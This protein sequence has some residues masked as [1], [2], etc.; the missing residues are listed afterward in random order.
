[1]IEEAEEVESVTCGTI[2]NGE[3]YQNDEFIKEKNLSPEVKRLIEIIISEAGIEG[4]IPGQLFNIEQHTDGVVTEFS[5]NYL[6]EDETYIR[7]FII[8][9]VK[10]NKQQNVHYM[11][12]EV[13][14]ENPKK[15]LYFKPE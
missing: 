11:G 5:I 7:Y 8:K 12:S 2:Y 6:M 14:K 9:E 1:V 15:S 4:K 10:K 3:A 13:T